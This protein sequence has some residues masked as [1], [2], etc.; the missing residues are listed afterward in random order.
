MN[1]NATTLLSYDIKKEYVGALNFRNVITMEVETLH[2]ADTNPSNGIPR[3]NLAELDGYND[4]NIYTGNVQINGQPFDNAR[5]VSVSEPRSIDV[6]ES[7]L[8]FWKRVVTL[9]FYENGDSSSVPASDTSTP[10]FYNRLAENLFD[11]NISSISEEFS[12][13]DGAEGTLEFSHTVTVSCIDDF[14]SNPTP[15]QRGVAKAKQIAQKLIESEVNFG[16]IGNLNS[17]YTKGAG[18]R[19]YSENVDVVNGSVSITKTYSSSLSARAPITYDFQVNE[20]GDIIV[21]E[22][23]E[24]KNE[25]P[26]KSVDALVKLKTYAS[27]IQSGAYL[28][29]LQY[30]NAYSALVNQQKHPLKTN[31]ISIVRGFDERNQVLTQ[32]VTY[33]NSIGL[34]SLYAVEINNQL[35]VDKVGNS[36]LT[37][38]AQFTRNSNKI[39]STEIGAFYNSYQAY[40][41]F[42]LGRMTARL[43][44]LY[45]KVFNTVTNPTLYLVSTRRTCGSHSKRLSYS[46]VYTTNP[47][48]R[49]NSLYANPV[50]SIS[51]NRPRKK[52]NSF[53]VPGTKTFVTQELPQSD[54]GSISFEFTAKSIR[55]DANSNATKV[56][57]PYSAIKKMFDEGLLDVFTFMIKEGQGN[58]DKFFINAA[59]YSYNS[60]REIKVRLE[61]T[62]WEDFTRIGAK[63]S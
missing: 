55:T 37:E 9:E 44:N 12:F 19:R 25:E 8:T 51:V 14:L 36:T 2:L 52:V 59:S 62:Y 48:M 63:K 21:S 58:S 57:R 1:I 41:Q 5:V 18:K 47:A 32:T 24:L 33:T 60:E 40:I 7:G 15:S 17:I 29:C 31:L 34:S 30:F 61:A 6:K 38:T 49:K 28:R 45:K 50:K 35:S 43:Q 46:Y 16:F 3:Y 53:I 56:V 10:K 42:E 4:I 13:S 54:L 11:K 39:V 20:V 23:V 27:N 22:T 26:A